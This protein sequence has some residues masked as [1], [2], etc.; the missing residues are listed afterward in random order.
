M[1]SAR[2]DVLVDHRMLDP[3][4][5]LLPALGHLRRLEEGLV[6]PPLDRNEIRDLSRAHLSLLLLG[7]VGGGR[8][9]V[10]CRFCF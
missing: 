10:F 7:R 5:S 4:L 1:E 2:C 8:G 6:R 3:V 9:G